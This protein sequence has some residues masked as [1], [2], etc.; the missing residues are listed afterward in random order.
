ML[1]FPLINSGLSIFDF[2]RTQENRNFRD[3][4]N[5]N[6]NNLDAFPKE[7][8]EYFNDN[9]S[10]RTPLLKTYHWNKYYTFHISPHPEKT[11]IGKNGWFFMA[12]EELKIYEGKKE[13]TPNELIKFDSI[14]A[15]RKHFLDSLQIS[16]YWVIGPMKHYVYP[17]FLPFNINKKQGKSRMQTL[18]E[19]IE[20]QYP[21]FIINPLPKLIAAKDTVDLYFKLDNHWNRRAG[22]LVA[23]L[24]LETI[25]QNYPEIQTIKHSDYYWKDSSYYS[26]FH[27]G[28]VGINTLQEHDSFPYTKKEKSIPSDKYNFSVTP[29]FPY[30]NEFEKVYRDSTNV[31]GLKILVIR[32]SFSDVL[33]PFLKEP[34]KESVFIFDGWNY[35]LNKDIV[36]SVKPDIVVFLGLETHLE[37]YIY[38]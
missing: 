35:G 37:H 33:I 18:I 7:F 32:D 20:N 26:G 14:W 3:S 31:N 19:R 28:V 38:R 10:F 12:Q 25:G 2:E 9:F 29:E 11:I 5:I 6:I 1:L 22:F 24:I 15:I 27:R 8:E 17:E 21:N 36:L 23:N 4:I 34:F 13:F 16:S 30:P